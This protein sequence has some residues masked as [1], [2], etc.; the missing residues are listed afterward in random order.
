M[1]EATDILQ[2]NAQEV[3]VTPPAKEGIFDRFKNGVRRVFAG[4]EKITAQKKPAG[5]SIEE[6]KLRLEALEKIQGSRDFGGPGINKQ[7]QI[8]I[9]ELRTRIQAEEASS[10]PSQKP[11]ETSPLTPVEGIPAH[12]M[13][14]A[15]DTSSA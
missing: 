9:D 15:E 13:T 2:P 4:S 8:Q 5:E 1:A 14:P 6:A 7:D 11:P 10:P 3:K 12:P